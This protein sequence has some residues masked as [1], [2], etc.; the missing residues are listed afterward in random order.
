VGATRARWPTDA[1][2]GRQPTAL[3]NG[4]LERLFRT[5]LSLTA[6]SASQVL[7]S[8]NRFERKKNIGLALDAFAAAKALLPAADFGALHLVLAGGYDSI[9]QVGMPR[10]G[11]ATA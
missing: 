4:S 6:F 11:N 8:I 2:V 3:P 7:L 10:R 1:P 9:N 5:A